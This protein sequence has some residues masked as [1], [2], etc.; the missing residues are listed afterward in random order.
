MVDQQEQGA[1]DLEHLQQ[2]IKE[3][4]MKKFISII[5]LALLVMFA[6]NA[7]S[8]TE[9]F[10]QL[11]I[12]KEQMV[13]DILENP[14]KRT[15]GTERMVQD[16]LQNRG[17]SGTSAQVSPVPIAPRIS[18]EGIAKKV[19]LKL[20]RKIDDLLKAKE[21]EKKT[22]LKEA[23]SKTSQAIKE[24]FEKVDTKT[25][26]AIKESGDKAVKESNS[27]A[28]L[29]LVALAIGFIGLGVLIYFRTKRIEKKV[30]DVPTKTATA[31]NA[32]NRNPLDVIVGGHRAILNQDQEVL[33]RKA[34]QVLLVDEDI[35]PSI[36]PATFQ[37]H[38]ISDRNMAIDSFKRTMREHFNGK[39]E[40]LAKN[41]NA[42][43]ALTEALI[44]HF[45]I[46][47]TKKLEVTKL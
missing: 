13:Q 39:L 42:A 24:V 21:I 17:K 35:D 19:F 25:A 30:D 15:R 29:L 10:G 23:D 47:G 22:A 44:E 41:G 45:G 11:P 28:Y 6:S 16:I 3:A 1:A 36:T 32:F 18:E 37:L 31:V 43:A 20:S 33:D 14:S 38:E 8:T 2:A 40:K 12:S 7:T 34:Y 27:N 5:M 9:A 4:D 46:N 26:T